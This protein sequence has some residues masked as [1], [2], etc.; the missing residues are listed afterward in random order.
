[1]SDNRKN[2]PITSLNLVRSN[3]MISSKY[4]SSLMENQLMAIALTN[5]EVSHVPGK[6]PV[7]QARLYPGQL[8]QLISDPAHIYRDL[9][10]LAKSITGHTMFI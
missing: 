6:E 4:K 7:L 10:A 9:K 2:Q 5:I 3:E 1:M 8:K